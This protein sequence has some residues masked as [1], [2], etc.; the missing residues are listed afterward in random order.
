MNNYLIDIGIVNYNSADFVL[1]TLYCLEKLTKNK[2]F[3]LLY[4]NLL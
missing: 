4:E 1:N 3:K 2:V